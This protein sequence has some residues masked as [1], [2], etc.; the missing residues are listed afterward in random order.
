MRRSR[1]YETCYTCDY[2]RIFRSG[3][4]KKYLEC[5][6]SNRHIEL[7]KRHYPKWCE[8]HGKG[9]ANERI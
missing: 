7:E 2:V 9:R 1:L 8:L 4:G 5:A 3:N 6:K